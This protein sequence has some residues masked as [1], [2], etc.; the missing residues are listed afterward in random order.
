M[1]YCVGVVVVKIRSFLCLSEF[2]NDSLR[3]RHQTQSGR[4][5]GES[6]LLLFDEQPAAEKIL[7]HPFGNGLPSSHFM[8]HPSQ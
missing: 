2:E 3:A 4:E 8:F 6:I 7:P 5:I 1:R